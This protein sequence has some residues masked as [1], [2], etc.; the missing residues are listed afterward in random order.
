[1]AYQKVTV[2][3]KYHPYKDCKPG[4]VL[5]EGVFLREGKDQFDGKTYEFRD[6][7]KDHIDVLNS[8]G[9]LN[10]LMKEYMSPG[11]WG[12]ITYQGKNKIA[13][14]KFKGKDSHSLDLDIDPERSVKVAAITTSTEELP[15]QA[16]ED[17]ESVTL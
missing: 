15:S 14:G 17:L 10:Y 9:H 16:A 7:D 11:D 3:K 2:E 1:M 4:D 13:K 6:P 5:A 12:R 8:C